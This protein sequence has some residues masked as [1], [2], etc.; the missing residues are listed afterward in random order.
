[1]FPVALKAVSQSTDPELREL[2]ARILEGD[3]EALRAVRCRDDALVVRLFRVLRF[4]A[5]RP[6]LRLVR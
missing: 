2:A 6:R 1:M 3:P 4:R 5:V